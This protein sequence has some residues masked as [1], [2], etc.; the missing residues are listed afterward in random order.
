MG[1][2]PA[3]CDSVTSNDQHNIMC[4]AALQKPTATLCTKQSS[5]YVQCMPLYLDIRGNKVDT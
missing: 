4:D 1:T 5:T 2:H 3:L